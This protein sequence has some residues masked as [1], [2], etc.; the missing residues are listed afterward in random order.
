MMNV[1][2]SNALTGEIVRES[3]GKT[4]TRRDTAST[5]TL[6]T[7]DISEDLSMSQGSL[8]GFRDDEVDILIDMITKEV[9]KKMSK[10]SK[11]NNDDETSQTSKLSAGDSSLSQN[12]GSVDMDAIAELILESLH[13]STTA[14]GNSSCRSD[15]IKSSLSREFREQSAKDVWHPD[16]WCADV[17][18]FEDGAF[19]SST[20]PLRSSDGRLSSFGSTISDFS[21]S[22][23]KEASSP[24]DDDCSVISE[25]SSLTGVFSEGITRQRKSASS[26]DTIVKLIVPPKEIEKESLVTVRFDKL[27]VR[28]YEQILGDNPACTSG[29]SL[30]IGWSYTE[31]GPLPIDDF[32]SLRSRRRSSRNLVLSRS[33]REKILRRAGYLNN[34]ITEGVRRVNKARVERRQTVNNLESHQIMEEAIESAAKKMKSLLFL[35]RKKR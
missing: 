15:E 23:E 17:L 12:S 3:V 24:D 31:L 11:T 5:A 22:I 26:S 29:P 19:E 21:S 2:T 18:D 6:S 8:K 20:L 1:V 13:K 28:E 10:A 33:V 27:T 32:E 4:A 34:E 7:L 30:T 35:S 16:F 14:A 9:A 25:L